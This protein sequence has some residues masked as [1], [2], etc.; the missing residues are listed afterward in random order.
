M[1]LESHRLSGIH[2]NPSRTATSHPVNLGKLAISLPTLTVRETPYFP[3]F[4]Q[5]WMSRPQIAP[6][7]L[8]QKQHSK[9]L[10]LTVSKKY[11]SLKGREKAKGPYSTGTLRYRRDRGRRR[12]FFATIPEIFT[13]PIHQTPTHVFFPRGR[14]SGRSSGSGVW[15]E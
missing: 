10:G 8:E 15:S 13:D 2:L 14:A 3:D 1:L 7:F 4:A 9:I 12:T 6:A 11:G 5:F